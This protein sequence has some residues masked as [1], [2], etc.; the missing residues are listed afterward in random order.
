MPR[1]RHSTEQIVT[2]LRQ[3]EVELGRG[4]RTPQV[5]KKIGIS[6]QTDYRWAQ[7]IWRAAVWP[8]EAAEDALRSRHRPELAPCAR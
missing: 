5:C 6:E 2:K 3:A 8:G 1:R 4:Q 7:G